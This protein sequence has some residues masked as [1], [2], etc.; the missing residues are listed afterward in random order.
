MPTCFHCIENDSLDVYLFVY[1][2]QYRVQMGSWIAA[3]S[4]MQSF[5]FK[6]IDLL[7]S[8]M[9]HAKCLYIASSYMKWRV[10]SEIAD[11]ISRNFD[12]YVAVNLCL[13]KFSDKLHSGYC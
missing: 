12:T 4:N 10:V 1:E 3:F 2:S 13:Y 7:H 11:T 8:A 6:L 9:T 5:S